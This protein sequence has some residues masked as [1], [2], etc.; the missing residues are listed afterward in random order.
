MQI[1]VAERPLDPGFQS[2][3]YGNIYM[4][5]KTPAIKAHQT[6]EAVTLAEYNPPGVERRGYPQRSWED[7]Q[8]K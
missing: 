8:K 5:A 7:G 1:Q 6:G 3:L 2:R 4:V